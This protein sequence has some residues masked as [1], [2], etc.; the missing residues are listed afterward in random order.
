MLCVQARRSTALFAD[1]IITVTSDIARANKRIPLLAGRERTFAM[2][3]HHGVRRQHP[4]GVPTNSDVRHA[5]RDVILS[6]FYVDANIV[7]SPPAIAHEQA[8]AMPADAKCM[9]GHDAVQGGKC[10][11]EQRA[12]FNSW[13]RSAMT[14][15]PSAWVVLK[16]FHLFFTIFP[17]NPTQNTRIRA[18]QWAGALAQRYGMAITGMQPQAYGF[19]TCVRMSTS[20]CGTG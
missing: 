8:L 4:C 2:P 13:Q 10:T 17:P 6:L 1:P 9:L 3:R 12:T 7:V 14:V 19:F 20:G 18:L 15:A 11:S 5:A 16:L